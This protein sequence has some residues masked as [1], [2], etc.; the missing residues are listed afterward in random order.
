MGRKLAEI[1]SGKIKRCKE[2]PTMRV[3][4]REK[5]FTRDRKLTAERIVS[6]ILEPAKQSLQT[7]LREFGVKFMDG[8]YATKQAFSKQRQFVNPDYIREFYDETTEELITNGELATFKGFHLTAVDG[9]RVA[10]ENTP[11]LIAEFGC[12]GSKRDACTA[13]ASVAYDVIE[14][15][16][17]DCQIGSYS[18]SERDLLNRHLDRLD[19]FLAEKF[20]IIA[21]RG[22][23]SYDLIETLI[24][25]GFSF[26]LRLSEGWKNIISWMDDTSDKE[27]QYEYKGSTYKFRALKIELDDK[28]EYL[29]TDLDRGLL[30]LDEAKRIYSLRWEVETFFGAVKTEIELENFSGK[31]KNAVL[32]EFYATMTLANICYCFI[33]DADNEIAAGD[34]HKNL[35]YPR[36]ANRRQSI[37]EIVPVFLECV[38]T[39]SKRKRNR[40]WKEVELFCKRFPEQVRLGRNPTRKIPRDKKFHPNARKPGLS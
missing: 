8:N 20:L 33:N 7:R 6:M 11:E 9:S 30:S 15:V 2:S 5:T 4:G 3:A 32:Q 16:S 34:E 38:F 10:C 1:C 37:G 12:S 29:V 28:A 22:Y 27:F 24:D 23:P 19:T 13:L 21:D 26:L 14:R 39:D 17:L 40:L 31:T 35:K 36:Q 25:R 18:L